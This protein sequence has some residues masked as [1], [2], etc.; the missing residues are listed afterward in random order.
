[1]TY[2]YE[3]GV[4]QSRTDPN[5]LAEHF[6]YDAHG[7]RI[8]HFTP[9]DAAIPAVSYTYTRDPNSRMTARTAT[10]VT[11]DPADES[12]IETLILIDGLGR[13]IYTAKSGCIANPG[14][15]GSDYGSTASGTLGW[16]LSGAIRCDAKGRTIAQG[17]AIFAPGKTNPPF[18]PMIN[19][20]LTTYDGLDRPLEV[21]YPSSDGPAITAYSYRIENQQ[22]ITRV[23]DP[24]G[25]ITET[26]MDPLGRIIGITRGDPSSPLAK[27]LYTYDPISQLEQV[28]QHTP[29]GRLH[30]PL[31]LRPPGPPNGNDLLRNRRDS[32]ALRRTGQPY[33]KEHPQPAQR[34]QSHHLCLR[35]P[36]PPPAHSAT[37]TWTMLPI[38]MAIQIM[39]NTKAS[40]PSGGS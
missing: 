10:K 38:P 22:A 21:Q 32:S 8:S 9:Y 31:Q 20:T 40:I 33:R 19:P 4:L 7:R 29:Q 13:P 28:I 6:E 1:M 30:R 17:Q 15:T 27:V 11:L 34:R 5:G 37:P 39:P 35:R 14:Y 12:I 26:A 16:N 36:G 23:V 24:E 2:F 25:S 3:W 18:P